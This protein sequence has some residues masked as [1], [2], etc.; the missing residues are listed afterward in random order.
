MNNI[1]GNEGFINKTGKFGASSILVDCRNEY[2][3]QNIEEGILSTVKTLIECG[4]MTVTSCQGHKNY[5]ENRT[6][7]IQ[8]EKEQLN[9]F[10]K[11][12]LDINSEI[13]SKCCRYVILDINSKFDLYEGLF[14]NPKKIEIIFGK[15]TNPETV[16][17]QK[18]FE[19]LIKMRPLERT[20][21][22][23]EWDIYEF[24]AAKHID[25][26]L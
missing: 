8:V 13:N 17:A 20:A 10:K 2:F 15:C 4:Y 26:I 11:I 1:L 21:F 25:E 14:K 3:L 23:S 18:K 7:T 19:T 24:P 12:I 6:V 9:F 16:I 22:C 5:N